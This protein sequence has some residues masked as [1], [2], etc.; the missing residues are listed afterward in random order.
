MVVV[1]SSHYLSPLT[2]SPLNANGKKATKKIF[3]LLY[4]KS[5]LETDTGMLWW[6]LY[7]LVC[8]CA[9]NSCIMDVSWICHACFL[10]F[11]KKGLVWL[12]CNCPIIRSP[13]IGGWIPE[14]QACRFPW[15]RSITHRRGLS[16][17]NM[18]WSFLVQRSTTTGRSRRQLPIGK[19]PGPTDVKV[20]M[21]DTTLVDHI[22]RGVGARHFAQQLG[23]FFLSLDTT[24]IR[25]GIIFKDHKTIVLIGF[26]IHILGIT[27]VL[28][29]APN[30][31]RGMLKV[32]A[33]TIFGTAHV[34]LDRF[35][36]CSHIT[37]VLVDAIAFFVKISARIPGVTNR[38]EC[39]THCNKTE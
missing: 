12:H 15:L 1:W 8:L 30:G 22:A 11:C 14:L 34:I 31:I 23:K 2:V 10:S 25:G 27:N 20:G 32:T 35:R 24:G 7:G 4:P 5:R 21:S 9:S 28:L 6:M 18:L 29:D 36:W 13:W 38:E 37:T 19:G 17:P 16:P 3:L 33:M 39:D 26:R